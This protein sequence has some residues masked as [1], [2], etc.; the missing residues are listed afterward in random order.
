MLFILFTYELHV[1]RAGEEV[2]YFPGVVTAFRT[3][4]T[5]V[6]VASSALDTVRDRCS[7]GGLCKIEPLPLV[8]PNGV[9]KQYL[10]I[11]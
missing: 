5:I 6:R 10:Y 7:L 3:Q 9:M 11:I 4:Q 8:L 2:V 1:A